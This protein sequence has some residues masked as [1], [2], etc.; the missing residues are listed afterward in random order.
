MGGGG[1]TINIYIDQ[2]CLRCSVFR[3]LGAVFSGYQGPNTM[4]TF[5][6]VA[7]QWEGALGGNQGGVELA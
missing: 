4:S 5:M 6:T 2:L 7:G 3:S 1:S